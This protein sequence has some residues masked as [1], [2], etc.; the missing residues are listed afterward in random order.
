MASMRSGVREQAQ[1]TWF[2]KGLFSGAVG[3]TLIES[4]CTLL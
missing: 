4:V 2:E 3:A 1:K